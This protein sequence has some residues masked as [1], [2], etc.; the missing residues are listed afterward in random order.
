MLLNKLNISNNQLDIITA[1]IEQTIHI[2]E[3]LNSNSFSPP[4]QKAQ[5]EKF[6]KE[7]YYYLQEYTTE[8][9]CLEIADSRLCQLKAHLTPD[10][11]WIY[12][13]EENKLLPISSFAFN[14]A[15]PASPHLLK[16]PSTYLL[17]FRIRHFFAS[18]GVKEYFS[19]EYLC[20][21]LTELKQAFGE[22]PLDKQTLRICKKITDEMIFIDSEK[23]YE[24][25]C[26]L[27]HLVKMTEKG[28][29]EIFLPDEK[30]IL[31]N[32]KHLFYAEKES[33]NIFAESSQNNIFIIHPTIA[34][35]SFAIKTLKKRIFDQ[36]GE[37]FGQ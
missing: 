37:P 36:I 12:S 23:K 15:N 32:S 33:L 9:K 18:M 3:I 27:N 26:S 2:D 22:N 5:I 11:N 6:F 31:R 24:N 14:V 19:L 20:S 21:K 8:N 13:Q 7:L 25:G 16:F 10:F 1:S 29:K 30:G 35:K 17:D 34:C 4:E 28:K